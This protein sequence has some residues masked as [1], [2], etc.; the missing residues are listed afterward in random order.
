MGRVVQSLIKLTQNKREISFEFCNVTVTFSVYVVWFPALSL[1][2]FKV[3]K[4]HKTKAVKESCRQEKMTMSMS[5]IK[6]TCLKPK[7]QVFV[8]LWYSHHFTRL[9]RRCA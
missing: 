4:I 5:N 8:N 1:N 2:N 7:L 9:R 3:L 6:E